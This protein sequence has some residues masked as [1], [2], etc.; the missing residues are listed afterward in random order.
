MRGD[1]E[2]RQRADAEFF[3]PL[4]A[5]NEQD[6]KPIFVQ[7]VLPLIIAFGGLSGLF[8]TGVPGTGKTPVCCAIAMMFGRMHCRQKQLRRRAGWRRGKQFD[9]FRGKPGELQEAILLDDPD[10]LAIMIM[11]LMS[12]GDLAYQG[13]SEARYSPPKWAKNQWRAIM[14]NLWSRDEEPDPTPE[15]SVR[16][17]VFMKMLK[18]CL[19][20]LSEDH[21]LAFLKRFI[22]V[23]VGQHA[24]YVRP[25]SENSSE[26]VYKFTD[27]EV[28]KDLLTSPGHK[29]FF[30]SWKKGEDV[31]YPDFQAAVDREQ[32]LV[33]EIRTATSCLTT[34]K[35]IVSWWASG[36][37]TTAAVSGPAILSSTPLG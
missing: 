1:R 27:N 28:H 3:F 15:R 9:V 22:T 24:I 6:F 30:G 5:T 8:I 16:P 19:G 35:E 23:V 31:E 14:S 4:V 21:R 33:E 34:E 18:K 25:P 32:A 26:T 29:S 37:A 7:K 2:R 13:H 17:E 10:L 12:F 20:H 36:I 11:D